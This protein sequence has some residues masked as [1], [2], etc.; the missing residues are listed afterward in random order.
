MGR[1]VVSQRGRR[2]IVTGLHNGGT[3]LVMRELELRSNVN[4]VSYCVLA[5]AFVGIIRTIDT[6][7]NE[8]T[9]V[10]SDD[11]LALG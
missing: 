2:L 9:K 7:G 8:T 4:T 5:C 10:F 6:T 3:T 1:G 11:C